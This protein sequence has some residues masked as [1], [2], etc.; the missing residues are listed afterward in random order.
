MVNNRLIYNAD[1]IFQ[2]IEG[3]PENIN[4]IIPPEVYEAMGWNEGDT[5]KIIMEDGALS[6]TK[7]IDGEG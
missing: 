6:I 4:M 2:D 3:D 1:E 5:L 7:V